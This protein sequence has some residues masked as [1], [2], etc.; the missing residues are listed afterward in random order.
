[1]AHG[2]EPFTDTIE[3]A[4]E[5]RLILL[6]VKLPTKLAKSV[7]MIITVRLENITRFEKNLIII[8]HSKLWMDKRRTTDFANV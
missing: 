4:V 6:I 5:L 8:G 2:F 1:L 7:S 3:Q